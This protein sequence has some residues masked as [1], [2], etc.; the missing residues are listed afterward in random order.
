MKIVNKIIKIVVK[1]NLILLNYF[2]GKYDRT[3]RN[4]IQEN[5]IYKHHNI[6]YIK[7]AA[8]NAV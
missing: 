4:N 5:K 1:S 8:R 6:D 3:L 2:L 7:S